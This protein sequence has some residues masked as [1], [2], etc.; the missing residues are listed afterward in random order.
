[1]QTAVG[2]LQSGMFALERVAAGD[3]LFAGVEKLNQTGIER[4][5]CNN[6]A[7]PAFE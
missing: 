4:T 5:A 7:A 1:M 6:P 2:G 3:V